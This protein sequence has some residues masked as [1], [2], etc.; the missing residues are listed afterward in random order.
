M[1]YEGSEELGKDSKD[2]QGTYLYIGYQTAGKSAIYAQSDSDYEKGRKT[3]LR[4]VILINF[5]G[6][7]N[8]IG[9]V[10]IVLL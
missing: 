3:G 9:A 8:W 6:S 4:S 7:K 10:I 5:H 1:A 2:G